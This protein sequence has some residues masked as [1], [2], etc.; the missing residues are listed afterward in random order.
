MA[1]ISQIKAIVQ[2][3]WNL[4]PLTFVCFVLFL[5]WGIYEYPL[6]AIEAA[7]DLIEHI[8]IVGGQT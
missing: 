8:V 2:T 6:A 7:I 5:R 1:L 4:A 3:A